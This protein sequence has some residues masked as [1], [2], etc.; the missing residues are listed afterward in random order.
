M[1]SPVHSLIRDLT[2]V[3]EL[4]AGQTLAEVDGRVVCVPHDGAGWSRWWNREDRLAV[5]IIV[6]KLV[7][8]TILMLSTELVDPRQNPPQIPDSVQ[9]AEA[10]LNGISQLIITY[11]NDERMVTGVRMAMAQI[12]DAFTRI[13][14]RSKEVYK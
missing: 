1:E 9:L 12:S 5:L 3:K 14:L 7:Y 4:Q 10:A 13:R 8:A 2:A 6:N 11:R